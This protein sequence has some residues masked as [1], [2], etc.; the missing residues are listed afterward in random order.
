MARPSK[1]DTLNLD[2]VRKIAAK[3]WTDAEM[4]DFFN[5]A[6][7]TWYKWKVD[8]EEFS[9]ALKGWKKE[10]DERVERSLY[11]RAIGY[12][13]TDTKFATHEGRITDEREY[14]KHYAPDTTA[15][16]FWLKN[17]QP[18]DWKDKREHEMTGAEGQPLIPTLNV[19]IGGTKSESS[20]ETG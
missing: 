5:V 11:E 19:T 14:I 12:S 13:H 6:Q 16:I 17:R 7:S 10:A 18:E 15:A 20:S 3:G 4:A 1:F 2:Q 8:H 9:E